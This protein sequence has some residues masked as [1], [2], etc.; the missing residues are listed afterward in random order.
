MVHRR[1]YIAV[2]RKLESSFPVIPGYSF[3]P[4]NN[5]DCHC[6]FAHKAQ[7]AAHNTQQVCVYMYVSMY[8][9]LL[10]RGALG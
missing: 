8:V 10:V 5:C 3:H 7:H 9:F 4:Q 1:T 2:F 6:M